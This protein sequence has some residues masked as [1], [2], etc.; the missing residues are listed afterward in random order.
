MTC[1]IVILNWN[2]E[3]MLKQFLPSVVKYSSREGYEIVVADNGSTDN[4]LEV[5]CTFPM[6]RTIILDQNYGFAEG[7]NK[8]LEQIESTYVVLL[9]SDIEVTEGW[10]EPILRYMD[11]HHDVAAAQPKIRK[12]T[13]AVTGE[14]QSPDTALTYPFEHAGAAGGY[15]DML[16]YPFCRGRIMNHVEEDNGQYDTPAEIFWATGCALFIR[17][18][19]YKQSGG[20]DAD[21][22][23]HM[24]E[25][26]LCWRLNCRGYKLA[27]IPESVVYHVG[28]GALAYENPRKTFLNFRNNMLL[29]YK[30][31]PSS[32]LWWVMLIRCM[33]DY[34]A[35]LQYLLTGKPANAQAVVDARIAYHR[36]KPYFKQKRKENMDRAIV[37]Y[38]KTISQRSIIFDY[39]ICHKRN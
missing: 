4:S 20:L 12:Y 9:N 1:S 36:K 39:Y 38:P 33:L 26:D 35:A 22:F 27:C 11:M 23:A 14:P 6:V 32:K 15:M 7:Y 17:T 13:S 28:G 8:A 5:L 21:F 34:I 29:L 30:N 18:E 19:I 37:P 16:G 2:G 3:K 31:L 24:E 10:I 25:I